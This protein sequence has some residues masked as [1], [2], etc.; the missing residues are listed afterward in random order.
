MPWDV[1][2]AGAS[3]A[4]W[5]FCVYI[6]VVMYDIIIKKQKEK[7]VVIPGDVLS[8]AVSPAAW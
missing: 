6:K 1:P 5:W 2:S 3:A 7:Q 8:V 4:D